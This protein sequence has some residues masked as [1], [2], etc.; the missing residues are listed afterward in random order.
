MKHWELNRR[1]QI[2]VRIFFF[3][4]TIVL[5]S[6]SIKNSQLHATFNMKHNFKKFSIHF[7]YSG[8]YHLESGAYFFK[9]N[10]KV[11]L[12]EALGK[13]N[14]CFRVLPAVK[15][16][17]FHPIS[18]HSISKSPTGQERGITRS[19]WRACKITQI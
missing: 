3:L 19:R 6:H 12:P 10:P 5:F 17:P 2:C 11:S 9:T 4:F 1:T 14:M 8:M 7:K 13:W 15:C 18:T 16:S